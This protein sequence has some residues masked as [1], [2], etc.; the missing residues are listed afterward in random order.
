MRNTQPIEHKE[1]IDLGEVE[2]IS[3][4][5][6]IGAPTLKRWIC[7]VAGYDGEDTIVVLKALGL[8]CFADTGKSLKRKRASALKVNEDMLL[9]GPGC[10][11]VP[12]AID[13][14]ELA[15]MEASKVC[16]GQVLYVGDAFELPGT[17]VVEGPLSAMLDPPRAES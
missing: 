9:V 12:I 8:S 11:R 4:C 15:R 7:E 5:I 10:Y 14:E 1:S 16:R 6:I 13:E 3:D 2:G 17:R